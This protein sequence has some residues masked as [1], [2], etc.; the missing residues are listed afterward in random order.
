MI[1]CRDTSVSRD[2]GHLRPQTWFRTPGHFQGLQK[3]YGVPKQV[4]Q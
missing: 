2:G 4:L 3:H 1:G